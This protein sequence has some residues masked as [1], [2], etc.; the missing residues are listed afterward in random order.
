MKKFYL[1]LIYY[2]IESYLDYKLKC[3]IDGIDICEFYYKNKKIDNKG[4][5]FPLYNWFKENLEFILNESSFGDNSLSEECGIEMIEKANKKIFQNEEELELWIDKVSGWESKHS[6]TASGPLLFLPEV[7]FRKKDKKIEISWDNSRREQDYNVKFTSLKGVAFIDV[8]E[9]KEEIEKFI[10]KVEEI[11]LIKS[12][13]LR[14]Y[15]DLKENIYVKY[16]ENDVRKI[17]LETEI[18][19][20]LKD[21]GYNVKNIHQLILLKESDK[22]VVPILLKYLLLILSEEEKECLVRFLAVK[23][24]TEAFPLLIKE[25]YEAQTINYR[26]AL[27]NTLSIIY[28][29]NFLEVLLKIISDKKNGEARIP[30]ILG[31]YKY[32]D[33]RVLETLEKLLDDN[34]VKKQVLK[35]IN[36]WKKRN[37]ES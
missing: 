13:K 21:I 9:F 35:I 5:I 18:L 31:L 4:F 7:I 37:Q 32:S 36:K 2:P 20:E 26:L 22:K 11:E 33:N 3:F 15:F 30:I 24:F 8:E 17:S 10:L 23:S 29:E 1:E 28:D 16:D 14:K 27:S 19:K 12:K 34:Q 25:F 6:W